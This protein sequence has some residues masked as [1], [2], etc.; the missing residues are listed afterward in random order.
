MSS[1]ANFQFRLEALG[2]L[3][4]IISFFISKVR[5]LK[6]NNLNNL[7]SHLQNEKY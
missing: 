6:F 4:D 5:V 3:R 2:I 7:G 1:C